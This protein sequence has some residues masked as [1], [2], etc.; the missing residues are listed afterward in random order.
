[1]ETQWTMTEEEKMMANFT[2]NLAT[3]IERALT[4]KEGHTR[5]KT[6]ALD[7]N[8][9]FIIGLNYN[10]KHYIEL[11]ISESRA[12]RGKVIIDLFWGIRSIIGISTRGKSSSPNELR[13]AAQ[14]YEETIKVLDSKFG[15]PISE[16]D[17]RSIYKS[18]L[19]S[20]V[21]V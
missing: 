16:H 10:D 20:T 21:L 9:G 11:M 3:N 18:N 7:K 4:E 6:Y 5:V 12:E 15:K 17:G 14:I 19:E 2:D 13:S 1:M 8:S